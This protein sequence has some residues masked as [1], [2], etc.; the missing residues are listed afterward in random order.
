MRALQMKCLLGREVGNA[1]G[2]REHLLV[3]ITGT[4]AGV[5]GDCP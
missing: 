1:Y 3:E 4:S 2:G 5:A